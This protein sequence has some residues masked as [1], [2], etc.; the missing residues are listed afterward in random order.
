MIVAGVDGSRASLVAVAWAVREAAMRGVTVRLVHVMPGLDSSAGASCEQVRRW[1]RKHAMVVVTDALRHARREEGEVEADTQVLTGDPRLG[2]VRASKDAELLVVGSHGTGGFWE[3]LAGSV[4]L[5][6]P[7]QASCP[8][9]VVRAPPEQSRNEVVVGVDGSAGGRAATDF[10]F[11]E[12]AL[13]GAELH[14]VHAWSP[15]SDGRAAK[16]PTREAGRRLLA[17][18][19]ADFRTRYPGVKLVTRSIRG[20]PVDVLLRASAG[21]GLLVMGSRGRGPVTA[22]FGSVSHAL[23]QYAACPLVVVAVADEE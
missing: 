4:A 12:A 23:V 6:V 20:H 10:A 13:R 16:G 7:G 11:A 1:L 3:Q 5:G 8:V 2:L 19:V 15:V 18:T 14:A 21:A 17:E 22:F 9:V